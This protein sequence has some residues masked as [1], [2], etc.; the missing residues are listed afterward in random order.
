MEGYMCKGV[1]VKGN[2][3]GRDEVKVKHGKRLMIK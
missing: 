2:K 3:S 1:E